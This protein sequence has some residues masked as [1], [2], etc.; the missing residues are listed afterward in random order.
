M[1]VCVEMVLTYLNAPRDYSQLVKT[2]G[3]RSDVGTPFP[4]IQELEKLNVLVGYRRYG[5]LENLYTLLQHG[6]PVIASVNTG[7]LPYWRYSTGH[8]VVVVGMDNEYIYLNDPE[9]SDGPTKVLLGDF[10]LA[11]LEQDEL[12]AVLVPQ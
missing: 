3:I 8:A 9:M 11:W 6:W 1:A 5:T 10:D 7:P 4:N 2:L 12:Y